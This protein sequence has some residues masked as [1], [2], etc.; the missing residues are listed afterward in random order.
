MAIHLT[1]TAAERVRSFIDSSGSAVG[2]R[3]GVKVV[4][5]SGY[6]YVVDLADSVNADDTVFESK[7]VKVVVSEKNLPIVDGTEI[8]FAREGLNEGFAYSNPNAKN[9]CGCGES[10]GV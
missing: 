3:L 4:G 10:F 5:C 6:A 1:D 7:G 8:D 9:M 2:L